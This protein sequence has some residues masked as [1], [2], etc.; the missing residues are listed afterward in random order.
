MFTNQN[1]VSDK[2][3]NLYFIMKHIWESAYFSL[4]WIVWYIFQVQNACMDAINVQ[5]SLLFVHIVAYR[6]T[7]RQRPWNKQDNNR[8]Y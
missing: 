8:R 7:A 3:S 5:Y 4:Q 6:P 2:I 1:T